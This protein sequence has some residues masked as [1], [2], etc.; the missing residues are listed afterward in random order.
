LNKFNDPKAQA[1]AYLGNPDW[2]PN[3]TIGR[4]GPYMEITDVANR[5]VWLCQE[6][7]SYEKGQG[8]SMPEGFMINGIGESAHDAAFFPRSPEASEDGPLETKQVGE[9]I[10]SKVAK[11]GKIE[12]GF[13]DVLVLAVNKYHRVLFK[14]GRSIEVLTTEDGKDYVPNVYAMKGMFANEPKERVLPEEW[15]IRTISLKKDVVL[16][17]P[18]PARVCFFKTGSG[19]HGPINLEDGCYLTA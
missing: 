9:Y 10:F 5:T 16:D 11:P 18:N 15:S 6:P 4:P 3:W 2:T 8:L 19:F 1:L 17:I 14:K 13:T 12:S 7:I